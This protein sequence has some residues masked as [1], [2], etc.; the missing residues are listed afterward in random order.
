M[1][2]VFVLV[3]LLF[4]A[5]SFAQCPPPPTEPQALTCDSETLTCTNDF[6]ICLVPPITRQDGAVLSADEIKHYVW[7]FTTSGGVENL[8]VTGADVTQSLQLSITAQ[9]VMDDGSVS[10]AYNALAVDT[11]DQIGEESDTLI[12]NALLEEEFVN[13]VKRANT[14]A[15]SKST[16]VRI[17]LIVN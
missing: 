5:F 14:S 1:K 12:L 11:L 15:P 9:D 10:I 6:H 13:A 17:I 4:S 3:L 16:G 2:N 7:T 8:T